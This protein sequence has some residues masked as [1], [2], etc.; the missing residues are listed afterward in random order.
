MA[1][2]GLTIKELFFALNKAIIDGAKDKG[3][4]VVKATKASA[5]A[6]KKEL[7]RDPEA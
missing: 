3:K 2:K 6:F 7:K 1:E 5:I 4:K